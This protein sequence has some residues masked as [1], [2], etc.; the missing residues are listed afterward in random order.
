MLQWFSAGKAGFVV[1]EN[2]ERQT[3]ARQEKQDGGLV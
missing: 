2:G 1:G 3:F